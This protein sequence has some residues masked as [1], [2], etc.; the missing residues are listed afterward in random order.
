[1]TPLQG[2]YIKNLPL[3][4]SQEILIDDENELR[5][6]LNLA[7]TFDFEQE[8]LQHSEQITIISPKSFKT[9]MNE[10]WKNTLKSN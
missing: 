3:H 4:H 5:I 9:R 8:L 1:F 7:S 2:K 6:K 10:I